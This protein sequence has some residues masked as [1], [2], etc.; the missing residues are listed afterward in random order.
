MS[1][2]ELSAINRASL[3]ALTKELS[4]AEMALAVADDD[5][6]RAAFRRRRAVIAVHEARAAVREARERP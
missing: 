6:E 4:Y 3:D 1:S 2:V 5:L